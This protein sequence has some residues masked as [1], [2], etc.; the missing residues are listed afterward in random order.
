MAVF[1]IKF[2]VNSLVNKDTE[3]RAADVAPSTRSATGGAP[4]RTPQIKKPYCSERAAI[5]R[6]AGKIR[7]PVT[8]RAAALG[9]G[10]GVDLMSVTMLGAALS[11][12]RRGRRTGP[13]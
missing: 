3:S 11:M 9:M 8:I 12:T 13:F 7:H 1:P 10:H 2:P 5:S 4:T 6:T